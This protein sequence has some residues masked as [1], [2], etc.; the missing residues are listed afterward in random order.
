MY[1]YNYLGGNLNCGT[2]VGQMDCIPAYGVN[3]NSSNVSRSKPSLHCHKRPWEG[4][5]LM[6]DDY[7]I[8]IKMGLPIILFLLCEMLQ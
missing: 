2:R 1:L 7:Y 5:P 6:L 3:G 8:Y 4:M